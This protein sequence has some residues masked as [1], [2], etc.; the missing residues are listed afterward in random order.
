MSL[1]WNKSTPS[2]PKRSLPSS[3]NG[4]NFLG[5][6]NS[7][8]HHVDQL[9]VD[10]VSEIDSGH[11][12]V[13][14]PAKSAALIV[15]KKV[16]AC[17]RKEQLLCL[18]KLEEYNEKLNRQEQE[19]LDFM[20]RLE[21]LKKLSIEGCSQGSSPSTGSIAEIFQPSSCGAGREETGKWFV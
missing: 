4:K 15:D 5:R 10:L 18:E 13:M 6:N 19:Q 14:H 2:S 21:Q 3:P 17:R 7:L 1:I 9:R 11:V 16:A 20:N 8:K 12:V